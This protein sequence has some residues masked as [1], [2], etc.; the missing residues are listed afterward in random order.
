MEPLRILVT[1][2]VI[3]AIAALGGLVMAGMRFAG[4]DLPPTGLA[5]LHGVLAAA[6]ITLLIYAAATIGLSGLAIA[7]I[8]LFVVAAAGGV[9]MNLSYHWKHRPLPKGIVV[10]HALVAVVGF[11]LLIVATVTARA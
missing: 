9:F 2:T 4:K 7:A 10:I 1:S 8:L 5:M 11:I 3:I 6:A